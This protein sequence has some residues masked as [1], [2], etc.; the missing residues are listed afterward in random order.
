[1]NRKTALFAFTLLM[2]L[3]GYAQEKPDIVPDNIQFLRDTLSRKNEPGQ[4]RPHWD[5]TKIFYIAIPTHL[6]LESKSYD[7]DAD[8]EVIQVF[9]GTVSGTTTQALDSIQLAYETAPGK[10]V[11][12]GMT[13]IDIYK[14]LLMPGNLPALVAQKLWFSELPTDKAGINA[15]TAEFPLKRTEAKQAAE[16]L[17]NL[18]LVLAVRFAGWDSFY[19]QKMRSMHSLEKISHELREYTTVA[20]AIVVQVLVVDHTTNKVW[21]TI[22]VSTVASASRNSKLRKLPPPPAEPRGKQQ[23][24][25]ILEGGGSLRPT[26]GIIEGVADAGDSSTAEIRKREIVLTYRSHDGLVLNREDQFFFGYNNSEPAPSANRVARLISAP[27]PKLT[28]EM[29]QRE[30]NANITICIEIDGDGSHTEEIVT[31]T[32]DEEVDALILKTLKRWKWAPV[33]IGGAPTRQKFRY[34]FTIPVK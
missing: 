10:K 22:P 1:M 5:S 13:I 11:S 16:S 28:D 14:F 30:W 9:G 33:I 3:P 20:K 31:G 27:Y 15:I 26:R 18:Q 7:Y 25:E 12:G 23:K 32:G 4:T 19:Q 8:R 17:P 21:K 29:K 34:S 24:T 6:N 2:V